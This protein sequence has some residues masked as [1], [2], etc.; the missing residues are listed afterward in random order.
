[1]RKVGKYMY[2]ILHDALIHKNSHIIFL[3]FYFK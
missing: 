2:K 3:N 1:M